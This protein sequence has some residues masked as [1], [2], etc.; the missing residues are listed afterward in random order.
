MSAVIAHIPTRLHAEQ[1]WQEYRA[2]A[3]QAVEQPALLA[4]LDYCMRL[5]RAFD[6][7]RDAFLALDVSA[8]A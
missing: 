4:D 6:R 8:A 2:L 7:W 3:G 5:A 1:A